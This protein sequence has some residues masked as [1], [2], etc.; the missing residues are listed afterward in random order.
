MHYYRKRHNAYTAFTTGAANLMTGAG[1]S[2]PDPSAFSDFARPAIGCVLSRKRRIFA[3]IAGRT[4]MPKTRISSSMPGVPRAKEP[5]TLSR[6]RRLGLEGRLLLGELDQHFGR[7]ANWAR[8]T[9]L[10]M[11][12]QASHYP[13]NFP[14]TPQILPG[15][16]VP[17]DKIRFAHRE[18]TRRTY[19]NSVAYA[20]WLIGQIVARLKRLGV[21]DEGVLLVWRSWRRALETIMRP[22]PEDQKSSR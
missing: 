11:N 18:W 2:P 19:W 17:R 5:S 9:F 15:R 4:G 14:G 12:V 10:Y 13:Y 20:D 22:W 21:L 8:P 16:P 1:P 3:R 7:R 6:R